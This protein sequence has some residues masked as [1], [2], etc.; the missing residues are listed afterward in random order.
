MLYK[1]KPIMLPFWVTVL[2]TKPVE[3]S[4]NKSIS[5]SISDEADALM[6]PLLT[7]TGGMKAMVSAPGTDSFN[8]PAV[9]SLPQHL[10]GWRQ[11]SASNAVRARHDGE[12]K[13]CLT[14]SHM[15]KV[16]EKVHHHPHPEKTL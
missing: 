6:N 14:S 8:P 2:P 9:P 3:K 7:S 16:F 10:L 5:S 15:E 11:N 1:F 4:I 12:G 13:D